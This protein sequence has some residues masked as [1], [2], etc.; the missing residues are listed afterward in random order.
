YERVVVPG[1]AG[2]IPPP[3]LLQHLALRQPDA[4]LGGPAH[5]LGLEARAEREG[6]R[7]EEVAGDQ[8]VGKPEAGEGRRTAAAGL[9]GVDDV[10]V[11]QRRRGG[12]RERGRPPDD[13]VA[14][15]PARGPGGGGPPPDGE[16]AHACAAPAGAR[17]AG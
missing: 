16:R 3:P 1:G 13:V 15:R 7:E 10:V 5:H 6:A 2:G 4:S 9:A 8:R 14:P 12:E 17:S 11:Q